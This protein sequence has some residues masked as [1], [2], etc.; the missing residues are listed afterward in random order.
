MKPWSIDHHKRLNERKGTPF[1]KKKCVIK[2]K[3]R[4]INSNPLNKNKPVRF[5]KSELRERVIFIQSLG[6]CQV[7]DKSYDLDYPHHVEQGSNK[8]DRYMINICVLCHRLIHSVGYSS[9]KKSREECNVI[10]WDNHLMF[11]KEKI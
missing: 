5:S 1:G 7:C 11:E 8:D 9:V 6:A 10:S 2:K 4:K 3:A